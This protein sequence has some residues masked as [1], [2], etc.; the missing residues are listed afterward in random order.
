MDK[1]LLRGIAVGII[2]STIIYGYFYYFEKGEPVISETQV[3]DYLEEKGYVS[4]SKEK[5][6]ELLQEETDI[7]ENQ[8][9]NEPLSE[10]IKKEITYSLSIE[11]GMNSNQIA[12]VLENEEII[13]NSSDLNTYLIENGLNTKIQIGTY[14]LSNLMDVSEIVKIICGGN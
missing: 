1:L 10:P 12:E 2:L 6:S 7:N 9:V 4:L 8:K 5:Y 13:Q 11:P 14:E 3:N